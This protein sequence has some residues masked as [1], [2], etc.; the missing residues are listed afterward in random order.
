MKP[1][2]FTGL[3]TDYIEGRRDKPFAWGANDCVTFSMDW[4]KHM[5]GKDPIADLRGKWQDAPSAARVIDSL[6]GLLAETD[7]RFKRI[8]QAFAQRGD[9]VAFS[10][11]GHLGLYVCRGTHA[12]GPGLDEMMLISMRDAVA[13]WES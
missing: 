1:E 8:D 12:V 3:L 9:I 6:G 13:A 10:V 2:G 5:R 11:N 4:V 7:R